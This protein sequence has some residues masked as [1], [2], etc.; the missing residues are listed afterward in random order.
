MWSDA[1]LNRREQQQTSSWHK[2]RGNSLLTDNFT[3]TGHPNCLRQSEVTDQQHHTTPSSCAR[4]AQQP[5]EFTSRQTC[6]AKYTL[7][8]FKSLSVKL[9]RVWIKLLK[10]PPEKVVKHSPKIA[11]RP[12][13]PYRRLHWLEAAR[14]CFSSFFILFVVNVF[15]KHVKDRNV[16]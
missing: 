5:I 13:H 2:M 3:A 8:S 7:N 9:S 6:A 14:D 11:I 1:S 4:S 10:K 15:F 12:P 16:T